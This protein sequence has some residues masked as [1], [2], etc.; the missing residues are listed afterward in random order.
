VNIGNFF[1]QI[2]GLQEEAE[3][4]Q[5][6][7]SQKTVEATAGGGMVT[8]KANGKQEILSIRIDSEVLKMDDK[9]M[10]ESLVKAGVNEAL[11][12]SRELMSIEIK[13]IASNLGPFA[14]ML[15]GII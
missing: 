7:L 14:S 3:K 6:E 9:E 12:A 10:L 15:K 8:V 11:R 4:I 1:G 13:K 2:K 5:K